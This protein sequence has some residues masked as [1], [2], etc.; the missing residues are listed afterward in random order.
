MNL[1]PMP[2]LKS[3]W[4]IVAIIVASLIPST[5]NAQLFRLFKKADTIPVVFSR[6]PT[7]AELLQHLLANNSKFKQLSSSIRISLDGTPKLRGTMQLELPRRL[8]IKAGVM[9]VSQFGV[10]VGSNDQDFWVWTKVNLPNQKPAIFHASH[11]GFRNANSK[12]RQAIPLEPVWLLE[13]LGLIQFEVTDR[14][15]LDRELTPE[16]FLRLVSTRQTPNG[17]NYRV[18]LVHPR[19]GIVRQQALYNSQ[20][21]RIA[22]TDSN[23]YKS[24][25]NLGISLPEKIEMHLFSNGQQSKMV[26]EVGDYQFDSLYG[27][28]MQMWALPQPDG[29]PAIDLTKLQ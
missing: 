24:F 11:E 3:G 21:Q 1:N 2:N 15:Q 4:M 25:P 20:L 17:P 12:V 6:T 22:Y 9:G 14:H 26:I 18:T 10:D 5:S 8:R 16:G 19:Q 27:D 28:P 7:Q 29:V 23:D 13:G